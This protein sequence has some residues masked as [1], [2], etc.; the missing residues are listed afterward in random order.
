MALQWKI[1]PHI[2]CYTTD[3]EY[4]VYNGDDTEN[5]LAICETRE[6]AAIVRQ[7]LER[8]A[9]KCINCVKEI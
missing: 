3:R 5:V 8:L 2:Y 7:A 6:E 9:Q 4:R 1:D